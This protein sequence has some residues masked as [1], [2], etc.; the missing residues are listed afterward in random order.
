[1]HALYQWEKTAMTT[2]ARLFG[3]VYAK[4]AV[5]CAVAVVLIAGWVVKIVIFGNSLSWA[6]GR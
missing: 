6:V 1:M 4:G 5:L 3:D 2:F